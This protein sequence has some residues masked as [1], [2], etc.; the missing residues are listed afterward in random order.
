VQKAGGGW[1][2]EVMHGLFKHNHS[3]DADTF[4]SYPSSRGIKDPDTA[5]RVQDMI[6]T[7][8]K[9]SEI[10]D[11]LLRH[12]ENVVKRDVDNLIAKYRSRVTTSNDGDVTAAFIAE[13]TQMSPDNVVT[14]DET[15][16]GETGV[17]SLT[18]GHMRSLY[19]RFPELILVDCTHQTN[20]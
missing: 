2:L 15:S 12:G 9:R 13:F 11:F 19:A 18:T 6:Q 17:I 20:R 8:T 10:Y 1:Q 3:I 4:G 16:T 7:H 14:V 5:Q